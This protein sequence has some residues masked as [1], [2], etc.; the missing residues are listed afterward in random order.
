MNIGSMSSTS[1]ISAMQAP[2]RVSETEQTQKS[3]LDNN[4]NGSTAQTLL[5]AAAPSLNTNGQT[6]GQLINVSA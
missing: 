1:S 3:G 2:M 5:S 6:V 4:Q